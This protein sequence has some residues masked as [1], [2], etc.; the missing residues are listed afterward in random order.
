MLMRARQGVEEN[1]RV[2][3]IGDPHVRVGKRDACLMAGSS[4]MFHLAKPG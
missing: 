2:L 4:A 3:G 1:K